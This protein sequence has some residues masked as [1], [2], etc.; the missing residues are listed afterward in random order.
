M[1]ADAKAKKI[2]DKRAEAKQYKKILE[3]A[4]REQRE[5][6]TALRIQ[7]EMLMQLEELEAGRDPHLLPGSIPYS[8]IV[9]TSQAANSHM[10]C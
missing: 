10:H 2:A 7:Y 6:W 8:R 3:N 4:T 9:V 1:I 5:Y